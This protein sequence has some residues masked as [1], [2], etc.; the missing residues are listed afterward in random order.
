MSTTSVTQVD[1]KTKHI[2]TVIVLTFVAGFGISYVLPGYVSS[3]GINLTTAFAIFLGAAAGAL[4][5]AQVKLGNTIMTSLVGATA[6][7][8]VT[9]ILYGAFQ[10]PF[11]A[12][13]GFVF[14]GNMIAIII[15]LKWHKM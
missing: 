7:T 1:T 10:L 15:A 4:L 3:A 9:A 8:V 12:V 13:L 5:T 2:L 11:S 6:T 14:V